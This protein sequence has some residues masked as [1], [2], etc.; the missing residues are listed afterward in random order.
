M[1]ARKKISENQDPLQRGLRAKKAPT[2]SQVEVP[3]KPG[4]AKIK[5]PAV[6]QTKR[7]AFGDITNATKEK[8]AEVKKFTAIKPPSKTVANAAPVKPSKIAVKKPAEVKKKA[9]SL[10]SSQDSNSS[11]LSVSS[12]FSSSQESNSGEKNQVLKNLAAGVPVD[13]QEEDFSFVVEDGE[14]SAIEDDKKLLSVDLENYSDVF[15]IG[16]YA[17]DIFDYYKRREK[18]FE[19]PDYLSVKKCKITPIMR[20][21]LVDWMVEIQ[22]NFELNHETLYLAI[23][24]SDIFMS[25][26]PVEKENLQLVGAVAVFIAAKFDERCPPLIE[27]FTY[28]CDN[29]FDRDQF[30]QMEM[31]ILRKIDFDLG[32]PISYRFLRRYAKVAK[33]P[34]KTLTLARYILEMSLMEY[35]L[36]KEKDSRIAAAALYIAMKMTD[37]GAWEGEVV[38]SSGYQVG[39]IKDLVSSL[40]QMLHNRPVPQLSTIRSKYSHVVFHEVAKIKPLPTPALL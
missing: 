34:M 9:S 27:D 35:G 17:Q 25:R 29:S 22:E 11:V 37:E 20:S 13:R 31:E 23:K 14:T 36:I 16:I 3:V 24:L 32:I 19:I 2:V 7:S 4:V 6:G 21:I 12:S 1:F 5:K 40:N 33:S 8:D 15:N 28:I 10:K 38:E 39:H 30:I 26:E 18:M